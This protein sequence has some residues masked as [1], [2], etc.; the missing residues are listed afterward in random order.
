MA[1]RLAANLENNRILHQYQF[2]FRSNHSTSLAL[3]DVIDNILQ[4]LDNHNH[5]IGIYLDLQKAFDTVNHEIL[6]YKLYNYGVRGIAYEWFS[7]YLS[8]RYQ[9]TCVNSVCS[10]LAKISCG[11]P[12]GSVLGPILFLIYVNDIANA[13]PKEKVKLFADDTNLFVASSSLEAAN[14][15]AN[16]SICCLNC[17]FLANKLSLNIEK[18]ML[19]GLPTR[20][21]K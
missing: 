5:V 1:T 13:V 8:D 21:Q 17:W 14:S 6:L 4:Q 20:F 12:Q 15:T 10:D 11:V 18:N 7:S 19:Y 2:G 9:F 16:N 3:I